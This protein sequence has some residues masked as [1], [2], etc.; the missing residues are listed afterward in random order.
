MSPQQMVIVDRRVELRLNQRGAGERSPLKST[1]EEEEE[2]E[3]RRRSSL[4]I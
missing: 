2:E 3:G 4:M 1:A